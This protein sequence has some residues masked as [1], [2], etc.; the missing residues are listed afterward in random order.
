MT[1]D[2]PIG[3][4]ARLRQRPKHA[5]ERCDLGREISGDR[6]ALR[7]CI[8]DRLIKQRAAH[9]KVF[10][11]AP[12]PAIAGRGVINGFCLRLKRKW[13]EVESDQKSRQAKSS[14]DLHI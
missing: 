2:D 3:L 8:S 5:A 6:A 7:L 14:F 10:G 9:S 13:C 1:N 4:T 12:L 11:P